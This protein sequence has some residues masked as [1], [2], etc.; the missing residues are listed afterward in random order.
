MLFHP[1]G[2]LPELSL[3][4][5]TFCIMSLDLGTQAKKSL[6]S[7][8]SGY[9][10]GMQSFG[11]MLGSL[12]TRRDFSTRSFARAVKSSKSSISGITNNERTPPLDRLER[13]ADVLA[14]RGAERQL[15]IDLGALAHLPQEA[16]P[17][18]LAWYDEY[19]ELK[20]AH[21]EYLHSRRVA[22]R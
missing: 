17:R 8:T 18:F 3:Y 16:Q 10:H 9:T 22:E 14:L 12:L 5:G 13:W 21:N 7:G 15:F 4:C 2:N 11:T 20:A 6:L 1:H 19:L